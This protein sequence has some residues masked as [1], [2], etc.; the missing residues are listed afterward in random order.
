MKGNWYEFIYSL[1]IHQKLW[2]P[3]SANYVPN[4]ASWALD[5][6]SLSKTRTKRMEIG[7]C[8]RIRRFYI[9]NYWQ[10]Q[11]RAD[12]LIINTLGIKSYID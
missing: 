1:N 7:L 5:P 6:Y 2:G 12:T 9:E 10:I 4:D 11:K 3:N 8:D